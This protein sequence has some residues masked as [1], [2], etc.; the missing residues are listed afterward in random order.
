MKTVILTDCF[1]LLAG[2]EY[3]SELE[4][5][6]VLR[7]IID[8]LGSYPKPQKKNAVRPATSSQI[9]TYLFVSNVR[10][11]CKLA[12]FGFI[13]TSTAYTIIQNNLEQAFSLIVE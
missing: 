7:Y 11:A 13:D 9:G 4:K 5:I 1:D 3:L 6:N 2:Y 10:N 8:V 12:E